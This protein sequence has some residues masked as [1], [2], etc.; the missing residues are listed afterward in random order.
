MRVAGDL[1]GRLDTL[2]REKPVFDRRKKRQTRPAVMQ[3]LKI[4]HRPSTLPAA[5][6]KSVRTERMA[7]T[8]AHLYGHCQS[9]VTCV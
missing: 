3:T 4:A 6:M 7:R 5:Y 8:Y 9:A 1:Q 2:K